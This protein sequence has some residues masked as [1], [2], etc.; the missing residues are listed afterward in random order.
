[1]FPSGSFLARGGH[2]PVQHAG[3]VEFAPPACARV[4]LLC[5]PRPAA[6]DGAVNGGSRGV[7]NHNGSCGAPFP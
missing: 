7:V 4:V 5:A 2:P 6:F 1:M 3:G